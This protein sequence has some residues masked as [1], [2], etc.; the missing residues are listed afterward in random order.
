MLREERRRGWPVWGTLRSA[1]DEWWGGKGVDT[2]CNATSD[3]EQT[4]YM[5]GRGTEVALVSCVRTQRLA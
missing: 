2:S 3:T 5:V 4:K 1:S